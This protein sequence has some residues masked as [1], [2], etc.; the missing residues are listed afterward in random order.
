MF[1]AA[2]FTI[3]DVLIMITGVCLRY[4]LSNS[5]KQAI[6]Q[7]IKILAGPKFVSWNVS[8]YNMLKQYSLPDDKALYTFYCST[9]YTELMDPV[10]KNNFQNQTRLC[11]KCNTEY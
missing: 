8:N 10:T 6:L 2:G 4:N 7:L 11:D 3:S 5:A 1:K 9:C